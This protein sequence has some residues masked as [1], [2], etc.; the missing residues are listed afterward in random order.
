MS[1]HSAFACVLQCY[2]LVLFY[3]D[4]GFFASVGG[5]KAHNLLL[6]LLCSLLFKIMHHRFANF[7]ALWLTSDTGRRGGVAGALYVVF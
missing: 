1:F 3:H 2:S 5:L 4:F 6:C 7:I